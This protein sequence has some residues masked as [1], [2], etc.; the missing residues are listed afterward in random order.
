MKNFW[1]RK[2][3]EQTLRESSGEHSQLK[4][5]LTR[6]NLILLGVGAIVGAGIFVLTGQAAAQHAGPGI[7]ISFVLAGIACA[8]AGLCYAE[9][10]A[11][12]PISGSAY[13]YAY[14]TL[15]EFIAWIIGWDLI[16]EYLFGASTV[17]V[18]WSGYVVHF[19]GDF[20]INL[21]ERLVNAPMAFDPNTS[22]FEATGA[23][24]NFPA[25]MIVGIMTTLLIF[26]IKESARINNIIVIVKVIVILLFVGYGLAFIDTSNWSPFVPENT[27][28]FGEYGVS[29]LLR[30]AGVIFFAYIG[31]D[32]VSTLAQE[33]KN[34]QKDMPW[35]ILGSLVICTGLYVVVGLVMTG[36]V[37]FH[38][39]NKPCIP[40]MQLT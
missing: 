31:F 15:G 2:S 39:L 36:V 10:A 40:E 12:I 34:P 21:P 1:A 28:V 16:L 29:G 13:A 7:T 19:L 3:I 6:T 35:G 27:G 23:I 30:A 37:D 25:M 24:F 18:G 38:M 4:R 11:M 8:F 22:S 9:F 32:A 17:A 20:G 33:A 26:G 5:T 14:S